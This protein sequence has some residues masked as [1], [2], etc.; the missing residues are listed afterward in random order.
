MNIAEQIEQ[1]LDFQRDWTE[2][3]LHNRVYYEQKQA[4]IAEY[5][6][7]KLEEQ[8]E[9]RRKALLDRE[10]EER[11]D[12]MLAADLRELADRIERRYK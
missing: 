11:A 1:Y 3:E 9:L 10:E 7:S 6:S 4:D 5:R 12:L 8:E 2:A